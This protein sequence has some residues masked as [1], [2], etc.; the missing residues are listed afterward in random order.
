MRQSIKATRAFTS[1][2]QHL[3]DKENLLLFVMSLR[4]S[5]RLREPTNRTTLHSLHRVL[6]HPCFIFYPVSLSSLHILLHAPS[7]FSH[8][9][10]LFL[11]HLSLYSRFIFL[12]FSRCY[13]F[14]RFILSH[15]CDHL[16]CLS[17]PW[18]SQL[19]SSS[20]VERLIL[21]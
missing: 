15:P 13:L 18:L 16:H 20:P 11:F 1:I 9:F 6:A 10:S 7:L 3:S 12:L 19:K 8:L 17:S 14:F 2:S 5:Y 21:G 4:F